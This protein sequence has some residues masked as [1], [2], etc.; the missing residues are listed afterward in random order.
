MMGDGF[1]TDHSL[2]FLGGAK[3][4]DKIELI[5]SLLDKVDEMIIGGG[6][7]YIFL[8]VIN[9]MEIRNSLFYAEVAY[10]VEEIVAKAKENKVVIHL[11]VEFTKAD[12][13]AEDAN[14]G[15]FEIADIIP[16][17]WMGS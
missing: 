3:V 8:K 2:L 12:Q 10:I 6:M 16:S 7:A 11:P 4:A 9:N 1:D 5:E 15:S 13:F 14:T 17:G